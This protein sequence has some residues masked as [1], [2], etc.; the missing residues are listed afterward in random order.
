MAVKV[1]WCF[2]NV[3]CFNSNFHDYP[4]KFQNWAIYTQTNHEKIK[5]FM[6]VTHELYLPGM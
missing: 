6:N 5:N 4:L 3:G 2:C 1:V